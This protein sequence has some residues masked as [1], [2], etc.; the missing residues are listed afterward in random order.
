MKLSKY[1]CVHIYDSNKEVVI[2]YLSK[3][4][5][6]VISPWQLVHEISEMQATD[7]DIL[8]CCSTDC[9][10]PDMWTNPKWGIFNKQMLSNPFT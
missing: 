6:R 1:I 8:N 10:I 2:K 3:E 7:N 5:N 4:V 9:D